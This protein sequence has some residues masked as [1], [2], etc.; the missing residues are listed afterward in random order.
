MKKAILI[1]L[2]LCMGL[3]VSAQQPNGTFSF[4]KA[5]NSARVA[6][7]G[8]LPLPMADGD[9]QA[10]TFNPSV[11]GEDMNNRLGLSYVDYYTDINFVTAQYARTFEQL[12]SFAATVQFHSYGKFDE[13]SESSVAMGTFTCSDYS[14]NIGWG[15]RLTPHWSIGAALKYAG[16]QY[17]SYAAG[18][19]AVDL[20]GNYRSDNGWTFSLTSR[21]MGTQL[22]SNY[23]SVASPLPFALD[24]GASKKLEHLPVTLMFWYDDIQ[25][26]NKLFE[27]PLDLAGN[28]DPFTGE[29]KPENKVRR[30]ARNLA[31]HV[32][33]GAEAHLGKNIVLRAS[34]NYCQRYAMEVP[35]DLTMVGFAAGVGV[36]I[37][38]FEIS[39][40]RSRQSVQNAPNY[41][42]VT[43][44]LNEF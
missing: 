34:Y 11:I 44:N 33:F 14:V 2:A 3:A 1:Q 15:R 24:L 43:M 10:S 26:W 36:K 32:V 5:T 8:G 19:L 41:L 23:E 35:D 13:T 9:I 7:L 21:N 17:E 39:Y 27:D 16:L 42:T 30:F 6:S 12:G 20:A 29:L 40:A 38:M 4:L 22:F 37:K 25:R 28:I 31:C 18:A